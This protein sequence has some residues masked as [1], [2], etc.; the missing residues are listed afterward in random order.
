MLRSVVHLGRTGARALSHRNASTAAA[1]IAN[2]ET[3][4]KTLS[5]DEQNNLTKQ[6]EELQKQDWHKLSLEEKRAAYYISFGPHGPREPMFKPGFTGKVVA[7]VAAGVG[8]A[9][10]MFYGFRQ[11]GQEKPRTINKEWE[12]ATNERMRQENINPITGVSSENY[13]GK[14]F[15]VSSQ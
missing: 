15:V 6:L 5:T 11:G 8:V 4:W 2:L 9:G 13:K 14:G 1:A 10:A 12:E 3:R 7:G